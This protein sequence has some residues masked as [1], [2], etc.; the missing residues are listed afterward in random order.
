[1][2]VSSEDRA[3]G[4]EPTLAER[5]QAL[6]VSWPVLAVSEAE[7]SLLRLMPDDPKATGRVRALLAALARDVV[8]GATAPDAAAQTRSERIAADPLG[9]TARQYAAASLHERQ[10]TPSRIDREAELLLNDQTWRREQLDAST[11]PAG[12]RPATHVHPPFTE[13]Q[14]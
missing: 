10:R 8:A 13:P 14:P 11:A 1:M 5:L 2:I 7:R 3:E 12:R 6:G 4:T 9:P